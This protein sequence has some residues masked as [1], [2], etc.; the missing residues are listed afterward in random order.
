MDY[1]EQVKNVL[2]I[3]K[4]IKFAGSGKVAQ[5]TIPSSIRKMNSLTYGDKVEFSCDIRDP[6]KII[7]RII[8]HGEVDDKQ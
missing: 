7:V 6:R 3:V 5:I 8:K 2:K 1:I 4:N